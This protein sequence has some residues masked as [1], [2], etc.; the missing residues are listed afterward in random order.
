MQSPIL[1]KMRGLWPAA[2]LAAKMALACSETSGS[3]G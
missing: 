2:R 3:T 1:E